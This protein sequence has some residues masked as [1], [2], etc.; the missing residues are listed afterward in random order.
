M[1]SVIKPGLLTTIQDLGRSGYQKFGV[2]ASG[3]MD[4]L[5]HRIANLLV[6]NDENAATMEITLLGPTLLFHKDALIAICGADLS[7]T[8]NG[9]PIRLWRTV[10]VKSGSML[11]FGRAVK[12]CRAYLS[13]AGGFLVPT[14]M[15]S[16]S[17]Y[18]RSKIGGFFGRAFQ[19]GDK[20]P[21]GSP[22]KRSQKMITFL[23]ERITDDFIENKWTI[24]LD[25][26]SY[27]NNS[28]KIR[29]LRGRHCDLFT[30]ESKEIFFK[31]CFEVTPQSDR[32]GYRLNGPKLVLSNYTEIISEAVTFGTIQVPA[33][34]NPIILM[35]D[36]QTTGGYPII[37]Q[38][39]TVDLPLLAQA[40]PGD[41]LHFEE[42]SLEEAHVLY[43]NRERKVRIMKQGI[44][45]KFNEGGD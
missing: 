38:V 44:A 7:P 21:F 30:E 5:A 9:K 8:I 36:R 39:I 19:A 25:L 14:V 15:N 6:G 16:K 27:Q 32:M 42:I 40:K 31:E 28:K 24:S 43:L 4:P 18:L 1:I 26:I 23:M 2:V 13:V 3:V 34:G 33:D 35:A 10:F 12:G 37:G 22:S 45:F 29:I 41:C 20:I 11:K 17:T